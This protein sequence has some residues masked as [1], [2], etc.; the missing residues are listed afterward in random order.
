[1]IGRSPTVGVLE[2]DRLGRFFPALLGLTVFA[3]VVEVAFAALLREPALAAAGGSTAV[4]AVGVAFASFRIRSGHPGQAR[5]SLA[6]S[7]VIF[8]GLGALLIPGV[9]TSVALLPIV[10]I[11]LV[12]PH[13]P[14]ERLLIVIASA[15]AAAVAILVL[16]EMPNQLPAITGLAGTVFR[17]G[18]LIG[19][20]VL[21]LAGLADYAMDARESIGDLR[22]AG[23]RQ[24]QASADQLAIVG[25]LRSLRAQ[26][27]PEATARGIATAL[28]DLPLVD[29]AAVL[30]AVDGGLVVLAIAGN[31][32][33]PF[34]PGHR[35]PAVRAS[36]MLNR[37]VEG[38]WSEL[39]A[40]RPMSGP[41]DDQMI[42]FGIKGQAFAPVLAGTEVVGLISIVVTTD[43]QASRLVGDVPA[44][45]EFALVSGT[46][47]APALLARR[48][49]RSA[50]VRIADIIASSA[51]HP[52]FQPIIDLQTGLTVGYEALTRFASGDRPDRMFADAMTVGLGADLEA[53][54]L[55][56]AIRDAARLPSG[57]WLSLNVSPM[58]LAECDV[59]AGL[60]S[61]RTR[62]IVLEITEHDVIADY[63]PLHEAMRR[64]GPDVKLAVD[65]AG[66]GIAN[67]GHLVDLRPNI[68]KIDAGLVRG[69]NADVSRQALIVGFVH[70][71]AV[72]GALVLAEGI[73]TAAEQQTVQRLGVT[74]AQGY[75]LARPAQI[76]AWENDIVARRDP[77]KAVARAIPNDAVGRP[78][79]I[80]NLGHGPLP[81]SEP[82][83]LGRLVD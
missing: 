33:F 69:V 24:L 45:R 2:R 55:A 82:A 44:V 40:D 59:L 80:F 43:D 51:F 6:V 20:L 77:K 11:V 50:R 16:N 75:Y 39:W 21:I 31:L 5:L 74:L 12:L 10:S 48:Q 4:F 9:G 71:A 63:A 47:L 57:A 30:E 8:G 54:T 53:A 81:E 38:A 42:D 28:V 83:I 60:L 70:F 76:D 67:F 15:V 32:D 61:D 36:Y 41:E 29:A 68:V 18:I 72:S 34:G 7:L 65:D 35:L 23:K 1:M 37:S 22:E 25:S 26:S 56:A 3:T 14:R 64:L 73:E 79:N 17:D 66:A 46:I 27:T 13:V 52:V 78:A 58:I 62:P 19:V 49:T